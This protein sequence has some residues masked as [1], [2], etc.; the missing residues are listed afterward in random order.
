ML[1]LTAM[2]TLVLEPTKIEAH[3]NARKSLKIDSD[4]AFLEK[5]IGAMLQ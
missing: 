3:A 5:Y 2:V 4:S 1:V